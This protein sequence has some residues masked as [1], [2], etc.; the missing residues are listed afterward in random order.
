MNTSVLSS[1]SSVKRNKDGSR[2]SIPATHTD[3]A[4]VFDRSSSMSWKMTDVC[5][6]FI[7]YVEKMKEEQSA[8]SSVI[9]L[10][11]VPFSNERNPTF[12]DAENI[13]NVETFD[14]TRY[15]FITGGNTRL[16]DTTIE[17][18]NEQN[19]RCARSKLPRALRELDGKWKQ[20]VVVIT[21]GIDNQSRHTR[22]DF[23]AA[24][25]RARNSDTLC[26]FLGADQDAVQTGSLYGFSPNHTLT[27][28]GAGATHAMGTALSSMT[29]D[30][31]RGSTDVGF[32]QLEREAS[33]GTSNDDASAR[34]IPHNL[35]TGLPPLPPSPTTDMSPLQHAFTQPTLIRSYTYAKKT[36]NDSTDTQ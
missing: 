33:I 23:N 20:I 30:S 17:V 32:T 34:T 11:I 18:I 29:S 5:N 8:N 13:E 4:V 16:Y 28:A 27:F 10:T 21:D 15:P 26:I 22:E 1:L 9:R 35:M 2:P 14:Q 31:I 7:E 6:G 3:I 25:T 19:E 12:I 24:I 36:G